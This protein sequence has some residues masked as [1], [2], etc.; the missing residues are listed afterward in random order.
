MS[1]IRVTQ[2]VAEVIMPFTE[3]NTTATG[4]QTVRI[5]TGN[6]N[7]YYVVFPVVDSG[8]ETRSKTVKAIRQ[9]GKRT[10]ASAKIYGYDIE[11][12][13]N[14]TDLEDGTNSTTGAIALQNSTQ[15]TQSQRHQVNV[16]NAVLWTVRIEGNDTGETTRDRIDEVEV[17]VSQIG[18]RR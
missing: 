6:G 5:G 4:P 16:P 1:E 3:G 15:V 9:T 2:V 11:D 10:N 18:V 14:V 7:A 8:E 12:S 13:I 17:E